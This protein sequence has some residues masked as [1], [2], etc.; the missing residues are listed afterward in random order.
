M[1]LFDEILL[2]SVLNVV[3]NGVE[4]PIYPSMLTPTT[5]E[6]NLAAYP[7]NIHASI[8]YGEEGAEKQIIDRH[9]QHNGYSNYQ[10]MHEENKDQKVG[11]SDVI[12]SVG[13]F[14]HV[15]ESFPKLSKSFNQKHDLTGLVGEEIRKPSSLASSSFSFPDDEQEDYDGGSN[16]ESLE[17]PFPNPT[18]ASLSDETT[19]FE[20]L[21]KHL[22]CYFWTRIFPSN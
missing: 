5:D 7:N 6:A 2:F 10:H 22:N 16:Q 13:A 3:V 20:T 15:I 14:F 18:T 19:T 9:F 12:H 8:Q 1:H 4:I 17:Q 11:L 21:G